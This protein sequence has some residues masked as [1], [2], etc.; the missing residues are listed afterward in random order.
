MRTRVCVCGGGMEGSRARNYRCLYVP[1][2]KA[3]IDHETGI[4]SNFS[5]LKVKLETQC[6]DKRRTVLQTI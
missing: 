5:S 6:R 3:C 4:H 2:C 1:L